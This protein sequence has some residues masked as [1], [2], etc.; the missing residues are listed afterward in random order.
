MEQRPTGNQQAP[1]TQADDD[2]EVV[3]RAQLSDGQIME[4]K[5]GNLAA[6]KDALAARKASERARDGQID[7]DDFRT[8]EPP[9]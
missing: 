1:E 3:S 5:A 6:A 8:V 4:I 7:P 9:K 2:D